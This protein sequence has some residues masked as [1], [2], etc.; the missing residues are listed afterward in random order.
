MHGNGGADT[1]DA[2]PSRDPGSTRGDRITGSEGARM[3]DSG[4]L[5]G[6]VRDT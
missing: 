2:L 4:T 3:R 1:G 5:A 6:L